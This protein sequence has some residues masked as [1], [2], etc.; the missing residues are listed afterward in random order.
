MAARD[1]S[2][3]PSNSITALS[4]AKECAHPDVFGIDVVQVITRKRFEALSRLDPPGQYGILA[5]YMQALHKFFNDG[6][7]SFCVILVTFGDVCLPTR[8]Y[9]LGKTQL[10]CMNNP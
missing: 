4:R 8:D 5:A 6:H 10:G 9:W 2:G 3:Y 7:S 1:T